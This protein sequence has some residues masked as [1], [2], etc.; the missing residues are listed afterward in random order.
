MA[1]VA[2]N[3]GLRRELGLTDL[4]LSQI[5][6]VV[7]SAWVGIAAGLGDAQTLVWVA[8][9]ILF[10]LPM[11]AS[12]VC[13]GREMPEEGGLYVWA[14]AAFGSGFGFMVAWNVWAYAMT[15]TATILFQIPSEIAYMIG[16]RAAGLPENH[17]AV[18]GL[19]TV[20]LGGLTWSSVR[21]LGVG[22]WIHNISGVAMLVVFAVL[23]ALPL[24]AVFHGVHLQYMPARMRLPGLDLRSLALMGQIAFA[25]SGLEYIAI[26]AGESKNAVRNIARSVW[27]ASPIICGMMVLG[28]SSVLSFAKLHPKLA[29]DFIAPIPQ[30]IRLAVGNAGWVN[31][32]A[33]AV[34]L[35]LQIRLIGAC[36]FLFTGLTRLPMTAGWDHLIPAWFAR[37]HPRWRTPVNS[38]YVSAAVILG[39]VLLGS[40]G[41]K[42]QEAFQVLNNAS[43]QLYLLAYLAMFAIP[44]VGVKAMRSRL[45]GWLKITS[46]AGLLTSLFAAVVAIYPFIEVVNPLAF[47]AKIAGTT[48]LVNVLGWTF[49]RMRQRSVPIVAVSGV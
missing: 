40:L 7:G 43:N 11:A 17:V 22:K 36:S 34:I 10:Y 28:T 23:I 12:V 33:M 16:P 14:K 46:M 21:G 31:W 37:L 26:L 25:L 6:T 35:L 15:S 38:V 8:V 47:A 30:T 3:H 24:W 20:I 42:A 44:L 49:Y 32:V 39:L 48:L 9:M 13:L 5:L 45:P 1:K 2:V 41:V 27:I 4:V 29:I 18:V 19:V